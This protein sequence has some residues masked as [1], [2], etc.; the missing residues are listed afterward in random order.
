MAVESK[1]LNVWKAD[2]T[3]TLEMVEKIRIKQTLTGVPT[4]E[5]MN[6]RV[7]GLRK[8]VTVQVHN[9]HLDDPDYTLMQCTG[10]DENG[11]VVEFNTSSQSFM[12]AMQDMLSEISDPVESVVIQIVGQ[13]SKNFKDR[14]FYTPRILDIVALD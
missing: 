6:G 1:I 8:V 14:N 10:V 7:V 4:T 3:N 11:E 5:E 2:G 12:D 13:P 9:P